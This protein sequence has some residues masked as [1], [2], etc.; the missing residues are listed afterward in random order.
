VTGKLALRT[1]NWPDLILWTG[2]GYILVSAVLLLIGQTQVRFTAGTAWAMA[3]GV[4]AIG[5]LIMLYV[6]LGSGSAAKVVAISSAYPVVTLMLAAAFL[7][8]ALTVGR[9][10]GTALIV[11]GVVIIT[12]V[13]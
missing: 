7:S 1:L 6:A 12:L 9:V 5:G 13:K 3:S 8:E 4:L 10:A 11:L 2:A